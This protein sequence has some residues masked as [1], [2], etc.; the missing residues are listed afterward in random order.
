MKISHRILAVVITFVLLVSG[1]MSMLG[2][3]A[4][5]ATVYQC[6]LGVNKSKSG[7]FEFMA[8]DISNKLFHTLETTAK[9]TWSPDWPGHFVPG[10]EVYTVSKSELSGALIDLMPDMNNNWGSVVAFTAPEAGSY[11]VVAELNTVL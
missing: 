7:Q 3:S 1:A 6:D 5:G 11:N 4:A 9:A 2:V 10:E 8:Y